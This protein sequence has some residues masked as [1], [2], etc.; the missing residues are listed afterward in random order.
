MTSK[1]SQAQKN[2][3][4][5]RNYMR[6][7]PVWCSRPV[8]YFCNFRCSMVDK[9]IIVVFV[10][11]VLLS[12]TACVQMSS[13]EEDPSSLPTSLHEPHTFL[14]KYLQFSQK[15]LLAMEQGE[16]VAKVFDAR[17]VENEVGAFGV[18]HLNIPKEFFV[19]QFRDI[20]KFTESPEV[21]EI[22]KFSHPP[23]LEDLQDM[24]LATAVVKAL[25]NCKP[26]SCLAKMSAGMMERFR[27]EVDWSAPDYHE[28]VTALMRRILLDY[29]TAYLKEGDA[30]LG[31]YDDQ[32][33][34]LRIADAFQGVLQ[35]SPYLREYVPE[36]YS[37][38]QKFPKGEL[39]HVENFIYWSNEE[40]GLR[41]VINIY[42]VTIYTRHQPD[43]T[44]IFITSKQIYASHYFEIAF[45][46]TAL[47]DEVGAEGLSN[48]YLMYLNRSRFDN[49]RGSLK[50][51]IITL[52]KNQV[53]NGVKRHFRHVKER[54]ESGQVASD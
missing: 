27:Q 35:N 52:A 20:V 32:K 40:F 11:V 1:L 8:T 26:G 51:L 15:D 9:I 2:F 44:D 39:P 34:P 25:K 19:E 22:A 3:R 54:L 18:V 36:L 38:L 30:A 33:D 14:Q 7:F 13:Y 45:G 41:P 16:V 21:K 4:L 24:T 12:M 48:S 53:Y 10:S 5:A 31:E 17:N 46:F 49:L 6:G 29:V 43:S 28:Q 47:V 23:R 50:G 37:Y 42:H